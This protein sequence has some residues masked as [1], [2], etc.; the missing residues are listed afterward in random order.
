MPVAEYMTILT[1]VV[2]RANRDVIKTA[3]VLSCPVSLTTG[4]LT[5]GPALCRSPLVLPRVAHLAHFWSCPVPLTSLT[6]G[7]A[8]CRSLWSTSLPPAAH[9]LVSC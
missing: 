4:P 2:A 6:S 1:H 8:L 3:V 9:W 7:P 5:S